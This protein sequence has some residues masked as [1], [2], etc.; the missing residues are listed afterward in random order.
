MYETRS[1]GLCTIQPVY[2]TPIR[3]NAA[4]VRNI[5]QARLGTKT[6]HCASGRGEEVESDMAGQE[7]TREEI[8]RRQ[9]V[10]MAQRAA[11]QE[12]EALCEE[13]G[14]SNLPSAD[15]DDKS[16]L[17]SAPTRK[18]AVSDQEILDKITGV[19]RHTVA[20][21]KLPLATLERQQGNYVLQWLVAL[22]AMGMISARMHTLHSPARISGR[23]RDEIRQEVLREEEQLI[24]RRG[25]EEQEQ[26]R[27][28]PTLTPIVLAQ[29][30]HVCLGRCTRS[31]ADTF[32]GRWEN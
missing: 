11:Q 1:C 14:Q 16:S 19:H 5:R 6:V 4:L 9:Q 25:R 22:S 31:C 20:A 27:P 2:S 12:R 24:K 28:L 29:C 26:V 10:W 23:L 18:S 32:S 21:D 8:K 13:L 7:V 17:G 15:V 3:T 30:L